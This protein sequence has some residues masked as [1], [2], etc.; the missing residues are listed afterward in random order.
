MGEQAGPTLAGAGGRMAVADHLGGD[1]C[2]GQNY[3]LS[4]ELAYGSGLPFFQWCDSSWVGATMRNSQFLFPVIE[5][6]HLFALTILLGTTIIPS[7]RLF[8]VMFQRQPFGE[9]ASNL[10]PCNLWS[11]AVM[12]VTG[13]RLF[14]SEAVKCYGND[15]FSCQD[16]VPIC[17]S[18]V[19]IRPLSK[20]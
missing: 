7:L 14:S 17:G 9:L 8:G 6:F 3:G 20:L 15:S 18:V 5:M 4:I 11:L 2:R 16:V 19:S 13:R 1:H 12:L 10:Q